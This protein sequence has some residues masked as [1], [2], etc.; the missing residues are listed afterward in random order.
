MTTTERLV[1]AEARRAE[2]DAELRAAQQLA[3]QEQAARDAEAEAKRARFTARLAE[4]GHE[5]VADA[6]LAAAEAEVAWRAAATDPAGDW[7]AVVRT[8]Q[9]WHFARRRAETLSVQVERARGGQPQYVGRLLDFA[10]DL[11]RAMNEAGYGVKGAD[12]A[13]SALLNERYGD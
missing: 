7:G 3:A 6:G 5:V 12:A 4:R 8:W 13:A 11:A 10:G 1:Q 2:A 9:E